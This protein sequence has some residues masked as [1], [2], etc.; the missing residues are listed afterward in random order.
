MRRDDVPGRT[1]VLTL[2]I[3]FEGGLALL[4]IF[5]GWLF[6]QPPLETL[7]TDGTAALVG[8]AATLP[9]FAGALV[10]MRWPLGPLASVRKFTLEVICPVLATCTLPDLAATSLL[11]GLGEEMLFRGFLQAKL[12]QLAGP[13]TGLAVASL[14]FGVAHAVT[15]TYAVLAALIGVYLGWLWQVTGNILTPIV[16]HALYDFLLLWYLLAG[17]GRSFWERQASPTEP[18]EGAGPDPNPPR[19]PE[20][21]FAASAA[22]FRYDRPGSCGGQKKFLAA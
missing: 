2:A 11:A 4:A 3:G 9:L 1:L 7:V 21:N 19:G 20:D 16:T 13:W 18:P 10:V 14:V 17:P 5:L 12:T 6:R 22:A 8:V 15:P